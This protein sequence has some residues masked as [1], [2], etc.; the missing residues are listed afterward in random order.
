MKSSTYMIATLAGHSA[1]DIFAGAKKHEFKTFAII[2]RGRENVYTKYF[3]DL[4]DESL[5]VSTFSELTSDKVINVLMKKLCVFIP[6]RYIQVYCD[7]DKFEESFPIPVFGNKKFL[8]F[9]ERE[10]LL[11]QYIILN[12]AQVDYPKQF[13]NYN[14]IDRLTIVKVKEAKRVWERAFFFAS[15]PKEYEQQVQKLVKNGKIKKTD[16]E[17]AVIEEFIVGAQVNFNFFYSPLKKR[18][19]LLGTDTRR[20]TNIDGLIRLP[21]KEQDKVLRYLTPSYVESGHVTVTV[22]ESLLVK[23]FEAAEKILVAAKKIAPPGIIGPF[24]LQTAITPGPPAEKIV[25]FDLSFRIPGSPG[26]EFTPYSGYMF[27]KSIGFGE[28]IAMEIK[29]ALRVKALHRIIS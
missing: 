24:A 17:K 11:N 25:I 13:V 9:E 7:I 26:T 2:Q 20:Q 29:E 21:S 16:L 19:E 27:G 15:T 1:L 3:H 23:A 12:K 4:I 14:D 8:R 22:K 10:G 6:H 28:R 18:L 5:I